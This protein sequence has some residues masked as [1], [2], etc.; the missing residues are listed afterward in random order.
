MKK[1]FVLQSIGSERYIDIESDEITYVEC[2]SEAYKFES[3]EHAEDFLT[4]INDF[5]YVKLITVY[6]SN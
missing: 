6:T 3:I 4:S 5:F 1:E 2:T